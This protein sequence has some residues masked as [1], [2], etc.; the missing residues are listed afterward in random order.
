M[1]PPM[2][3][4]SRFY[5]ALAI[6]GCLLP[7][8]QFLPWLLEHGLDLP[9]MVRELFSTCIGGFFGL[10]VL[11]SACV[12]IAFI[13]TEG[14]RLGTRRLWIPVL[15]TL[16]VGVSCGLPAFLYMRERAMVPGR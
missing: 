2:P 15:C 9:R 1:L 5:L 11:L 10:D 7:Y 12:L 14:R 8:W 4:R 3:P 16:L 13:R 6:A